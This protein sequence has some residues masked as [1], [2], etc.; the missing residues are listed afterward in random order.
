M[1]DATLEG[2]SEVSS[3]PSRNVSSSVISTVGETHSLQITQHKL[4][5]ANFLEWSQSV[6]LVIRGKGKLSYLTGTKVTPK[7]GAAGH[8]TW[9]SEN[10]MVMA[11]LINSMEPKIDQTYL[12]YKTA[13]EIWDMAHEMYSDLENSAQCFEVRSALRSTK[14]GNLSVTEYFN[15]LTKLWQEMDMFYETN[16]HCH[17][18]SL[19]YKQMLEKER[20]FDFLHGLSKE[21]DEVRGRLLGTKPF[22]NIREAYAEVRREESRK[23]VMLGVTTEV[24]SDNLSQRASDQMTGCHRSFSTYAPCSGNSKIRVAD[25]AL[26]SV[27]GKG[28]AN[29]ANMTLKSVLHVPNLKCNLVSI[30]KLTNDLNCVAKFYPSFGEFQ[31]LLSGRTISNA[32]MRD[33]LYYLED[34]GQ[35]NKQ[36]LALSGELTPVS[37]RVKTPQQNGIAERK[38]RHLLE[39]ARALMFTTHVPKHFWGEAVLTASY[40]INRLP[41]RVLR[42]KTLLS[43]LLETYPQTRLYTFLSPKVFGCTSFVHNTSPTRE[44]LY[45]KAIKCIFVGYSPSQKRYKRYCPTTKKMFVSLGVSFLEDQ[46]FYPNPTLQ[47]EILGEEKLW[48]CLIPLPVVADIPETPLGNRN[49][50]IMSSTDFDLETGEDPNGLSQQQSELRVYSRRNKKPQEVQS[51]TH[52]PCCQESN[53]Q[54]TAETETEIIGAGDTSNLPQ[55]ETQPNEWD[56]P[57]ALRKGVRS[58]TQHPIS[59][60]LS[61]SQLSGAFRALT[62]KI[63][64][65][66][67]PKNVQE[68]FEKPEWRAAVLEEMRALK[69][70]ETWDVVELPEGKSSVGCKW[71][72]TIK[73][74]S[75]GEI[76]R[77]KAR[78]VAKG[79]TQVFGVD[80]TETFA[81]V[82]KL[83]T[84]RVLLSLAANL[85]WALHQMDV[86]N[87]F[88][89]EELDEEVYM[90]LPPGFE[91]AIGNRKVCRLK[92]SLYGLKQSPRAWFDRFAKTIKRYGYQQG[93]TDHTLFFKHSQ[94]GKKTILIVYVDD[95]ILTGDDTEEM[96]RLKKTLRTEFEIKD[97]G[98]LRYFLGM[99]VARSK[100]GIIISQRKYTL[101]LL[102]ETGMLGCKPAETPIV[103]NMKLGRTRSG[104]LVDKG[105][106]Q[107][108]VG[109]LIYLSHTRPDIAFAS[110]PGKGLFFKKNELRS[111]EAF[112]DADWAGSVEDRRSTSGY[113]T[114]VW[115]NLVT[116][117][118]KKQPVVARSSAEAEF[119]ALAQ[120]TCELIWLKRLMEELKVSS[121]GPMKLYCDNKAATS[122]AHNPVHH[123]R[124]KHV[125]IDRHFIK[126]KI[127]DGVICMTYV[128]TKQQIAD[129]LTKGLPRPSS[130][131]LVDKLGMTNIYSPA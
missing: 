80:Y 73:Y 49:P 93:Q 21:L 26:S 62:E 92:K 48:D 102:K 110:T 95:I 36:A 7:E 17:E 30:S 37:I 32:K 16:W 47:E 6:M 25:G 108:L 117:R 40:L 112:T 127:E 75:D 88:L 39:T 64:G 82:A 44:K 119:R 120:G 41:S 99:E 63:E 28:S 3:E 77:H 56:I 84:I 100:K 2:S 23:R 131:V 31:D 20:V 74:K 18:D 46:P 91:G 29:L 51:F 12:F 33:G 98:Q 27:A 90:D 109:R 76:E 34:N 58:C 9:E 67:I 106:Y 115:G 116:W 54:V 129:V 52:Q 125:E 78:L 122:I 69:K 105:R 57:I 81:P 65:D 45:P 87:A 104:I 53:P 14:Q 5:G 43:I 35:V 8:S 71:V 96:E 111:V 79:F 72:F 68:A 107:R 124:T 128:P 60:Y 4:N 83:N 59:N 38:N 126:E 114:K 97:L 15:T 11:W 130:E 118:C 89:N 103:M 50:P 85:D 55:V 24:I 123:D 1:A 101:N 113:C 10:S 86:K 19:K 22:Q 13:K 121:M 61:Y 70:N 42:F 66:E 94:D